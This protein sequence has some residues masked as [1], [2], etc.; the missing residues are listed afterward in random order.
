MIQ[1]AIPFSEVSQVVEMTSAC[2]LYIIFIMFLMAIRLYSRQR[3]NTYILLMTSFVIMAAE[4]SLDL[5]NV[6]WLQQDS[7]EIFVGRTALQAFSFVF[8]NMSILRMYKRSTRGSRLQF[9]FLLLCIPA[10]AVLSHLLTSHS[11]SPFFHALPLIVYHMIITIYCYTVIAPRIGQ[12]V[13]YVCSLAAHFAMLLLVT[14]NATWF[15]S[16]NAFILILERLLPLIYYTLLFFILFERVVE[17]LHSTYRTSITDGLTGLFNRR[18]VLKVMRQY[19]RNEYK[20]SFIFCDIDNFKKVNDTFG[21]DQAD[22]ILKQTSLIMREEIDD[23]GITG[24]FGGEELIGLILHRNARTDQ[25]AEKIRQRV[26]TET[27]VTISIGISNLRKHMTAEDLIRE[28]DQ[29]MYYSK[30]NGKN[31]VT[32]FQSVYSASYAPRS[33]AK[34]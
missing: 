3:S 2:M 22:E 8:V 26:E 31:R 16:S 18:Y 28:A 23:Y 29:A 12:Q 20:I 19:I 27:S 10:I 15:E 13:K 17:L 5:V 9:G 7:H 21:H 33:R 25:I 32:A 6:S 1:A 11:V 34:R 24:R 14:V 4:R 30:T